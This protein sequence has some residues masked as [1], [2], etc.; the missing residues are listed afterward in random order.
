MGV[1]DVDAP[2]LS[3]ED[4]HHLERV[5]R[6]RSGDVLSVTDGRGAW[7]W[8][9]FGPELE[10]DGEVRHDPAPE[11]PITVAF[12]VVKGE[13]PELVVQKLTELGVDRLVPFVA[14][15]SVVRWEPDK[16]DRQTTR[17]Q[18]VAREAA[19]QCRRTWWPRID[20]L[21][22]FAQVCGL[23]GAVGADRGGDPPSLGHPTLLVGPEGGW[24]PTERAA[25]PALVGL[26]PTVLR[27]ETAAI[28]GAALLVGLRSGVVQSR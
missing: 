24:S 3:S 6:L 22:T 15:R 2:R 9:R 17:L 23:P 28:S 18:R 20:E 27:A 5:R 21:S 12:A 14:E 25:L 8:C 11:P 10:P 7:R 16:A 19:Q 13:R 4:H 1:D 26:G